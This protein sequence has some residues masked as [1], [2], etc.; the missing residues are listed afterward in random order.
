M[1][2]SYNDGECPQCALARRTMAMQLNRDDQWEC[3]ACHLQMLG[4]RGQVIILRERGTGRFNQPVVSAT[5]HLVGAFMTRES[6]EEPWG[7]G[8]YFRDA[9]DLPPVLEQ[10]V[11]SPD[12][13]ES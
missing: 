11:F 5:D 1:F 7:S 4:A 10:E 6:A 12:D 2:Q 9:A 13:S 3:P 8:G